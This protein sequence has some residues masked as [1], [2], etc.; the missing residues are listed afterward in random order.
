MRG[1]GAKA[2]KKFSIGSRHSKLL[3]LKFSKKEV[4]KIRHKKRLKSKASAKFGGKTIKRRVV[5]VP[6][7]H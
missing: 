5:L 2:A 6:A 4:G 3:K 7:K 1:K